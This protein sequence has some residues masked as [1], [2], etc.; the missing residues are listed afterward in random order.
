M[1]KL[2]CARQY[3]LLLRRCILMAFGTTSQWFSIHQVWIFEAMI[4]MGKLTV[5]LAFCRTLL[6]MLN[7]R[8][9]D[10]RTE[11]AFTGL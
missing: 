1:D 10:P 7:L 3:P 8:L 11:K 9:E 2:F 4:Q 5:T 6:C